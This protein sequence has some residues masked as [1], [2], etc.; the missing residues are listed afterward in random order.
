MTHVDSSPGAAW[1]G[2]GPGASAAGAGASS[3]MR[4]EAIRVDARVFSSA[5][6]RRRLASRGPFRAYQTVTV[7]ASG[8]SRTSPVAR[9]HPA[10]IEQPAFSW[11]DLS[12]AIQGPFQIRHT[13][14]RWP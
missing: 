12:Q 10:K 3:T 5:K 4:R 8:L 1:S 6:A 14:P 11:R 13:P 2:V 7:G 9:Y